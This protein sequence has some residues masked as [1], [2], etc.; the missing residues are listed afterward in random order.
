V[1]IDLS[2]DK[3]L[4]VWADLEAALYGRNGYGGTVAEIYAYRCV[5]G[6]TAA[7][8]KIAIAN[9]IVA[10]KN[11]T[12]ILRRF[13]K[14]HQ[15]VVGIET[16]PREFTPIDLDL[17]PIGAFDHRIHLEVVDT[18]RLGQDARFVLATATGQ[19]LYDLVA[20]AFGVERIEAKRRMHL[21]AFG[22]KIES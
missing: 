2:L 14:H 22:G 20:K 3:I 7:F 18:S 10:G 4:N 12:E 1:N 6:E 17:M 5:N 21:A 16:R 13:M 15:C 8:E 9:T 19:G 11:L